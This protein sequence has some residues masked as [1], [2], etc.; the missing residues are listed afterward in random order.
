MT[1]ESWKHAK[2]TGDTSETL[3]A[4]VLEWQCY[5]AMLT[6]LAL[7]GPRSVLPGDTLFGVS[8]A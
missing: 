1:G 2:V 5:R 6:V 4:T 3:S 7:W 8:L